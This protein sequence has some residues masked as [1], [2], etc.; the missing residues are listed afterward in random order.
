[1]TADQHQKTRQFVR[2]LG[3]V[4]SQESLIIQLRQGI[5]ILEACGLYD[6]ADA[7]ERGTGVRL[8]TVRVDL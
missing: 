6:A 8:D 5:E 7:V 4:Q 2:D 1:M 3:V